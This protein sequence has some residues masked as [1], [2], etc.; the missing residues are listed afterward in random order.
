MPKKVTTDIKAAVVLIV[1]ENLAALRMFVKN[2]KNSIVKFV[3][4]HQNP[5]SQD[6]KSRNSERGKKC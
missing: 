1:T 5:M 3:S 6:K 4:K 2:V